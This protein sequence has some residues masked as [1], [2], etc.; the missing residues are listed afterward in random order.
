[1]KAKNKPLV[2]VVMGSDSDW[3]V[4]RNAADTLDQFGV[5]CE[6]KVCSAHRT[7]DEAAALSSGAAARGIKVIIASAGMAAHLAGV[8]AAHTNL[9]VLGVPMKGGALDGLDALL[10][11]VQM[12]G[13]VP[14]GTFALGRA[15]AVNAALMAVQ[16]LALQDAGLRRKLVAHKRRMRENVEKANQKIAT[17]RL[18]KGHA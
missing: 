6:V 1:M 5:P 4:L 18:E 3:P 2:L 13:G 8:L 10:A 12:P 16:I 9:P 17:E 7:P 14:V 15:G 11:T